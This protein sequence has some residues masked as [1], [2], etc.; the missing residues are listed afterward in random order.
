MRLKAKAMLFETSVKSLEAVG[1]KNE[2]TCQKALTNYYFL[3][4]N[5]LSFYRAI[6]KDGAGLFAGWPQISSMSFVIC[7][8]MGDLVV[9]VRNHRC[10]HLRSSR[11][12]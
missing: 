5:V 9:C 12:S 4:E 6:R 10:T 3:S 8:G 2:K 7:I 1:K 11:P